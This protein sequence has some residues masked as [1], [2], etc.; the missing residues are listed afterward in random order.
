MLYINISIIINLYCMN[1]RRKC[2]KKLEKVKNVFEFK[3][4]GCFFFF[5][6]YIQVI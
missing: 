2:K 4:E 3:Q 5:F 6:N 1:Y